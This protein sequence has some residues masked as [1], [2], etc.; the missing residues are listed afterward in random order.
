MVGIKQTNKAA[1]TVIVTGEALVT[2]ANFACSTLKI[3][4]GS[5]VAQAIKKMIVSAAKRMSSAISLGVFWRLAPSTNAIIRSKNVSPGFALIQI[6]SQSDNTRVPP[7]TLLRSPP[8]SL[9]TGALSPVMTLSSTL[10]TPSTISPSA[11]IN[12]FALT[13]T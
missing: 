9:M 12:S 11:G 4:N 3:E 7:V 5:S 1:N 13:R 8:L 10:A 6:T 2:P